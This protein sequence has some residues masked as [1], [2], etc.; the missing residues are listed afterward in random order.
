MTTYRVTGIEAIRAT[1]LALP[2]ALQKRALR[3]AVM[4]PAV[5]V[6]D[7]ARRRAPKD[8]GLLAS[9]IVAAQDRKPELDGMDAR[10][11]VWVKWEGKGGA[12]HWRYVEFGTAK[13]P[14]QPFM[15]PAFETNAV[16]A[17]TLIIQSV[18]DD[19]PA[20]IRD[21]GGPG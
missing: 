6:R 19:L 13:M 7:D 16:Q 10:A 1:L 14:P 2:A 21:A 4:K 3:K 17:V 15:R 5:L 8:T 12:P 11:V 9:D 18:A 20:A